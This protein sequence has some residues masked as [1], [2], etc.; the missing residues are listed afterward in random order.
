MDSE[1]RGEHELAQQ[2]RDV[3]AA[4]PC[5]CAIGPKTAEALTKRGI[6]PD[7][8]PEEYVAGRS[9][10]GWEIYLASGCSCPGRK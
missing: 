3:T 4:P 9:C 8:V 6:T 10:P 2:V 1:G 5:R 7:F